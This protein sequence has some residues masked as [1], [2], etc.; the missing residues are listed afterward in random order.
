MI[1]GIEE[2]N[3]STL[4]VGTIYGGLNLFNIHSKHFSHLTT[5]EDLPS[6]N[7]YSIKKDAANYLWFTNDYTLYKFKPGDRIIRYNIDPAL[8]NSAF[9]S[10]GFYTLRDGRWITSTAT[11]IIS[12]R[13]GDM[14]TQV[15]NQ[16]KVEITEFR[17]FD[18]PVF[19]DSFLASNQPLQFNYKQ[20]FLTIEFALLNFSNLQQVKYYY[21]LSGVN[22]DWVNGDTKGFASYTNLQPGEYVFSVKADYGN[23]TT[24]ITAFKIIISPPFWKTWWFI[25]ILAICIFVLVYKFIK[26]REKS[27]KLVEAEKL[28]VQKLNAEQYKHEL[29]LE[30]AKMEVLGVNEKLSE[31]RLEALRSQMNPHFIFNCLNSIDNLIQNNEKEKATLYLSKFAKLIRSVLEASKSNV[32]PCWKDMETLKLYIELEDF[33]WDKKFSY[34]VTISDDIL[35]GDYK[36]PPLVIQPFV[37]NAIHH[38][39]LNKIEPDKNLSIEVVVCDNHICYNIEDNGVGRA[40]AG[41]YKRLNRP[42]YE[43]MGMQITTDRINLF[44]QNE[45]GSVKI[46]DLVNEQN[47]PAGTRVEVKLI[48][49]L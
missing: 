5:H 31:A 10:T 34:S 44:N 35:N 30:Q 1:Q 3:D 26:W 17:I 16:A 40:K 8:V 49:Q 13:P 36:V 9:K 48:N 23:H 27:I 46:I 45:N 38:G 32:V 41:M 12:F 22:K 7:V 39:L 25:L 42:A 29:M 14:D 11:E 21:R 24:G 15:S 19:I 28:K 4:V 37:E 33:R 6:N 18:L 43:S 20:N 47:E 2:Y